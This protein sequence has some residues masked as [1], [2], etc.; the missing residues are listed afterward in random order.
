MIFLWVCDRI[1]LGDGF[2]EQVS[3]ECCFQGPI[4]LG[5]LIL[6]AF[7]LGDLLGTVIQGCHMRTT[8]VSLSPASACVPT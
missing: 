8:F 1:L 4:C 2:F 3:W 7:L 5:T 6:A